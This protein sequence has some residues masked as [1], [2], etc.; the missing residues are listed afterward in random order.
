MK[1]KSIS[2]LLA[3]LCAARFALPAQTVATSQ[4]RK[5][6]VRPDQMQVAKDAAPSGKADKGLGATK[7]AFATPLPT[8]AASNYRTE[9][10]FVNATKHPIS[11]APQQSPRALVDLGKL[12]EIAPFDTLRGG[13]YNEEG[14]FSAPDT[15]L[16]FILSARKL[17][18]L[19]KVAIDLQHPDFVAVN[20][21]ER[22]AFIH[23]AKSKTPFY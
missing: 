10:F 1:A 22:R 16:Q 4:P 15:R 21:Y 17:R 7:S 2:F 20:A 12:L 11:I 18:W 14:S 23:I 3:V 9:Y 5:A 8:V 13:E 6:V 19:R